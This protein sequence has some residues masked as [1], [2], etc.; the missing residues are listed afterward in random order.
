MRKLAVTG[1]LASG[2]TSV[3]RILES[4]GAYVAN[5]D[6][7]VHQLLSPNTSVGKQV[8]SLLGSDIINHHEF[9]RKKI[10]Q[11]V[12]SD[13]ETLEKLEK[14]IHPAVM[15]E[16]EKQY[17]KVKAQKKYRLFVAEIPLLFESS[18][19]HFFD[20][21]LAVVAD[22]EKCKSRFE[23][24]AEHPADEFE[25]RMNRQLPMHQK[26]ARADLTI[27]NNGSLEDLKSQTILIFHQILHGEA[28]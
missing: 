27:I 5:A 26:A 21:V 22:P 14:I 25:R 8:V 12:F 20:Q 13:P 10:A 9:D 1:G 16:I 11:I 17:Q 18:G 2:K 7:I 6:E 28:S 15:D 19:H 3:C 4:C 23:K 24:R